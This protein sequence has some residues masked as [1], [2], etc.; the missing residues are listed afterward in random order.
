M[1]APIAALLFS[2]GLVILVLLALPGRQRL[3]LFPPERR[4]SMQESMARALHAAGVFDKTPGLVLSSLALGSVVLGLLLAVIFGNFYVAIAGPPIVLA[5]THLYLLSRQRRFIGRASDEM[6]PFLNRIATQVKGG[7]P[8]QQAYLDAVEE[9]KVLREILEDS[10]AKIASGDRFSHALLE[11]LPLLPLRMWAV[12]VR[13]LELY[14]EVGGDV[15]TAI[16]T[17]VTQVNSMLQLQAEARADYA[18][19]SK[20]QK[21]ILMIIGA[22]LA[23]FFFVIPDGDQKLVA[24]VTTPVGIIG[25]LAGL[26][27]MA[28]G[29]WF[30]NKQLRDVERKMA[31]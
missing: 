12:F 2:I 8:A 11:T 29:L 1:S 26:S 13:Q 28:F 21:L 19:Q 7:K 4:R 17:T 23:G 22:G 25:L 14:E 18:I 16:E 30:L 20:Q 10:A 15:T 24:L 31:F 6:I 3:Q 27:L 5:S 9:S